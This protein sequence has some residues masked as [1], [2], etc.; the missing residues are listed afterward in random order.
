MNAVLST[1]LLVAITTL[2]PATFASDTTPA[3]TTT[4]AAVDAPADS[5]VNQVLKVFFSADGRLMI[6]GDVE[7]E[8]RPAEIRQLA[9]TLRHM[10]APGAYIY[11]WGNNG[12]SYDKVEE[13]QRQIKL[14]R[15]LIVPPQGKL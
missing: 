10:A 8:S 9:T 12:P 1:A 2:A 14:A 5:G 15:Q 11:L 7:K 4:V 13:A 6:Q 3:V